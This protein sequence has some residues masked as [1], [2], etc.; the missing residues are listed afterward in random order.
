MWIRSQDRDLLVDVSFIEVVGNAIFALRDG[1]SNT[2]GHFLTEKRAKDELTAI[3]R[4]IDDGVEG[5]YQ[6]GALK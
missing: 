6:V 2:L 5:V 4:W 3:E 1:E